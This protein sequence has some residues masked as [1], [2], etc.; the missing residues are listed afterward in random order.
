[1]EFVRKSV[2]HLTRTIIICAIVRQIKSRH[3]KITKLQNFNVLIRFKIKNTIILIIYGV[4][5]E[6][7]IAKLFI[8]GIIQ[9][10]SKCRSLIN[11][12]G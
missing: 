6:E 8:A 10:T 2:R 11:K 9:L 1:M 7:S 3:A 12:E 5:V 4:T